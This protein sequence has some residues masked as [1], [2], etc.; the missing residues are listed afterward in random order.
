MTQLSMADE[1]FSEHCIRNVY[2]LQFDLRYN[3]ILQLQLKI[4]SHKL[5][6]DLFKEWDP[7]T[8]KLKKYYF[9]IKL[10]DV[11]KIIAK[12]LQEIDVIFLFNND[13]VLLVNIFIYKVQCGDCTGLI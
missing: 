9:A 12:G 4:L 11:S 3:L 10:F 8:Y 2:H 13:Y 7:E 1:W 6:I 5:S